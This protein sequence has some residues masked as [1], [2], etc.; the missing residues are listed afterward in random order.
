[1]AKIKHSQILDFLK[2][3]PECYVISRHTIQEGEIGINVKVVGLTQD[4]Q[5][6]LIRE[7]ITNACL[8]PKTKDIPSSKKVHYITLEEYQRQHEKKLKKRRVKVFTEEHIEQKLAWQKEYQ[9]KVKKCASKYEL[10]L[11]KKMKYLGFGYH[12][13]R[14]HMFKYG[15]NG[16]NV[17]F[18]DLFIPKYNIAIEVDGEYHFSPEQKQKDKKR[19]F[20]TSQ[21]H[22]TTF[23]IKNKDVEND[24]KVRQLMSKIRDIIED[25][26]INTYVANYKNRNIG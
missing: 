15:A 17:F 3:Y 19:D 14:Q 2:Q 1:M 21:H 22:I 25:K 13:E 24:F 20:I 12:I 9:E 18:F 16:G 26:K 23:R 11:L 8:I 10:M 4:K 7:G 5:F 6:A